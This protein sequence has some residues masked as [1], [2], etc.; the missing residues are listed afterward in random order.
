V[1]AATPEK[2][3]CQAVSKGASHK[4]VAAR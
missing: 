1:A 3:W 4:S 2:L